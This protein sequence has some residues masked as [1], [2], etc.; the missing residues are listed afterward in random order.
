MQP[1]RDAIEAVVILAASARWI[2]AS[3]GRAGL[4]VFAADLFGDR[5]LC[6]VCERNSVVTAYPGGLAAAAAGFPPAPW[7]Y[8]GALEHHQ[9][10]IEAIARDRPL[11]G[12]PPRAVQVVRDHAWLARSSRQSGLGHPETRRTPDRVPLDGS[13]LVK[14]VAGAGGRGIASWTPAAA[15]RDR[16]PGHWL[17]QRRLEGR[18]RSVS[19]LLGPDPPRIIGASEQL[20]GLPASRGPGFGWCGGVETEAVCPDRFLSLAGALAEAG[21]RGL[22]GV[23]FIEDS[24]GHCHVLEVNPRPTASMELFERSGGECLVARHLEACGFSL[25]ATSPPSARTPG[26]AVGGSAMPA[27]A[28]RWAKGILFAKEP[29]R[30]PAGPQQAWEAFAGGWRLEDAG[31]PAVADLPVGGTCIPTGSPILSVFARGADPEA[32]RSRLADRLQLLAEGFAERPAAAT[33]ASGAAPE[34]K[35]L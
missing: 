34:S 31:W 13:F 3:A 25:Q 14:P 32:A 22:V 1:P 20:I 29:L 35:T 30:L 16:G 19:L 26:D 28:C 8:G 12:C 15:A 23:D 18:P 2:A 17:W 33:S 11:A 7:I 21:C 10:L 27:G 24:A 5:D 6:D 4:K 9:D